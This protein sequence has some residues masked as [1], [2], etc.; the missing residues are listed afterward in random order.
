MDMNEHDRLYGAGVAITR[1]VGYRDK[2]SLERMD[3]A[4]S[5]PSKK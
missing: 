4:W 2:L 1:K 5:P 3:A